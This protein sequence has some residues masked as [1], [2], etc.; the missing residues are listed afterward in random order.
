LEL[1]TCVDLFFF[2]HTRTHTCGH[3][4]V[5]R[6]RSALRGNFFFLKCGLKGQ[7]PERR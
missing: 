6:A 4:R 1:R 2:A 3:T 5:P 7:S